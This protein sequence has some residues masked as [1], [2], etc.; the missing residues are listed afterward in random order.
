V[1][2]G[3]AQMA[4]GRRLRGVARK[5]GTDLSISLEPDA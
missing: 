5:Q 4:P 2:E 3:G 1:V